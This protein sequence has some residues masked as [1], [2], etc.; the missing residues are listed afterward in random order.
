[1]ATAAETGA[2]VQLLAA[3]AGLRQTIGAPLPPVDQR[4]HTLQL[5]QARLTLGENEFDCVW[6]AGQQLTVESAIGLALEVAQGADEASPKYGGD[7]L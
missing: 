1:L 2:A 5:Q 6:R 3:A 7:I 4:A